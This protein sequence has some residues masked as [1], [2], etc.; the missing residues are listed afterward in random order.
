MNLFHTILGLWV[1]VLIFGTLLELKLTKKWKADA[2]IKNIQVHNNF[3]RANRRTE[4]DYLKYKDGKLCWVRREE[5]RGDD[6][7]SGNDSDVR[8]IEEITRRFAKPIS[9]SVCACQRS[10]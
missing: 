9:S 5:L 2:K 3:A 7:Y 1:F 8:K 10:L 6:Y 4:E